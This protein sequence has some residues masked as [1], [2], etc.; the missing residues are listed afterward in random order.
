MTESQTYT[1]QIYIGGD[2][3]HA[4]QFC[5]SYCMAVGL[6]VTIEPVDYVYTGGCE[7][8]VRVGLINYPRF[9]ADP[10]AIFA[11]AL[12]LARRLREALAQHSFSIVATDKTVFE[13]LRA[14]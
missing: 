4:K 2:I 11:Q 12:D 14:A 6:C 3:V 9:P 8:G 1:A 10:E 7:A 5:Q 13:T